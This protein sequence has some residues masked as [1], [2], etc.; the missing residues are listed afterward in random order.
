MYVIIQ[1]NFSGASPGF[2][3]GDKIPH[4]RISLY[5]LVLFCVLSARGLS[6]M[7]VFYSTSGFT[8][9]IRE[10][11]GGV[12]GF[13]DAIPKTQLFRRRFKWQLKKKSG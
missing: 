13:Y 8:L 6:G 1:G 5:S 11:P 12:D 10:T 4:H 3:P 7:L 9:I 2:K